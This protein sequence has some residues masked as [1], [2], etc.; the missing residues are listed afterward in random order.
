MN[1]SVSEGLPLAL[2]ESALMGVPLI[3]TD[4][5]ASFRVVVDINGNRIGK[6]LA[7]NDSMS[8]ARA[9][10]SMLGLLDEWSAHADDPEGFSPK[11]SLRPT[12]E[13]VKTITERMY[14]KQA[15]RRKLGMLSRQNILDS[16]SGDRYLREHEQ[17][18]WIGKHRSPSYRMTLEDPSLASNSSWTEDEWRKS[19]HQ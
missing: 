2:G 11:L 17:M 6:L 13:E 7:P 4:V 16:F 5:G 3:C 18:L 19:F 1:S 10:I 12:P 9:Q 15:Y 14:E 8:L